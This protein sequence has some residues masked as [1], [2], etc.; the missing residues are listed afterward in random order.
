MPASTLC[1]PLL[2]LALLA[3]PADAGIPANQPTLELVA[4]TPNQSYQLRRGLSGTSHFM[5]DVRMFDAANALDRNGNAV[6]GL[7]RGYHEGYVNLGFREPFFNPATKDVVFWD[8]ANGTPFDCDNGFAISEQVIMPT[9]VYATRGE[10]CIRGILGHE[11][12]HHVE[13]GYVNDGGGT[14]CSGGYGSTACEG[15]ARAMQDKVY[16][17]LDLD[18]AAS[19]VATFRGEANGYLD[20]P[21][22][23]IWQS[24]YRSALFWTY[25]MEQYG[26][27][28][29]EPGLGADFL[30]DWWER[31]RDQMSD[32][33]IIGVTDYQIKQAKPEDH[34]TNAFHDFT[35]A[36]TLKARDLTELP[37]SARLRY[38]YRDE[39]PVAVGVNKM[40]FKEAAISATIPVPAN[41][42][43]AVVNTSAKRFGAR[44]YNFQTESC[45][46]GNTIRFAVSPSVLL[47][48][49]VNAQFIVPD[50]LF[51]LIAIEGATGPGKPRRLYKYR[52]KSWQQTLIQPAAHY[53][54]LTVIV[55]GWHTDFAGSLSVSC[56]APPPLPIVSQVNSQ[57]PM[58]SGAAGSVSL[59]EFSVDLQQAD[60]SGLDTMDLPDF[61]LTIDPNGGS[62][63]LPAVQKVREA[64][65]RI[66]CLALIPSLPEGLYPLR[67]SAAGRSVDI[68]GGLRVGAHQPEVIVAVDT[69]SSM[70]LPAGAAR[71]DA[72]KYAALRIGQS[73]P[74]ASRLGL[75][76]F[77][78][79]SSTPA[80]NVSVLTA[81]A[82]LTA[83]QRQQWQADLGAIASSG[84][85]SIKLGDVLTSSISSFS[86]QGAGGERHL[87]VF[88]DGGDVPAFDITAFESQ[89]RAAGVRVH[90]VALGGLA[91][92]P[93]LARIASSTGGGYQYL[94]VD[95]SGL[96]RGALVGALDQLMDR[97]GR[98]QTVI[99]AS[100][101]TGPSTPAVL[102]ILFDAGI[103]PASGPHVKIFD[104][105][106]AVP[107]SAVRLY[108]PDNSLVSAG[109]DVEIFLSARGFSYQIRNAPSGQW[110]LEVDP[111]AAGGAI[112][113]DYSAAVVDPARGLRLAFARAAGDNELVE[114]F[115]VG[116]PVLVQ[117]ALTDISGLAAP[118]FAQATLTQGGGAPVVL[119]LRDDGT[120]GDQFANDRVYSALYRATDDGSATA[121]LDDQTQAGADGSVRVVASVNLGSAAAQVLLNAHG[122]FAITRETVVADLDNDGLPD[123]FEL[124]QACLDPAQNDAAS[125]RDGDGASNAAEYL[126]G[127]DPCDV[128]TDDGGETDGS[129]IAAGRS[130]LDSLDDALPRIGN[131]EIVTQLNDHEEAADLPAF[132][133]SLRFDSNP[134]YATILVKRAISVDGPW[135]DHAVIDATAADGSYVDPGLMPGQNYC[136]QLIGRNA[137]QAVAAASDI[138]CAQARADSTAPR[139]SVILNQGDP[140]SSATLL[141][142][143]IAVDHESAAG[144]QMR[145]RLPDG[146][147]TGWIPYLPQYPVGV[148]M[149]VPPTVAA[150][151]LQLR[152]PAGNESIEY[153]DDIDLVPAATLGAISGSVRVDTRF[154]D[155]D[156]ALQGVYV[157]PADGGESAQL[158]A[159]AGEFTLPDLPPGSYRLAF[160]RDGYQTQ[161]LNDILVTAG[162]TESIGVVRLLPRPLFRDGFED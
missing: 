6:P 132:S 143:S 48:Q 146:S 49:Q 84:Q 53:N 144:M 25:L 113:F 18:P 131:I 24:S 32:P 16:S 37:E 151:S 139:G 89:A 161:Y 46:T 17:D 13:F 149:L 147:D 145:L 109:P 43:P 81:L 94:P 138:V 142:A 115:R 118:A 52:A 106:S 93:L 67:I 117:A 126:A 158:S 63:L 65:S 33:S 15:H 98:R 101:S 96:D 64:A 99:A 100:A 123:R 39:D 137:T 80:S 61:G 103:E 11:L 134:G 22:I 9:S 4:V 130:P 114:Y 55:S 124:R 150:V 45:P 107:F 59:A 121:I 122:S 34:V 83:A 128:D 112:S 110:R 153:G 58:I 116:E 10:S 97:V 129:E 159:A 76:S 154:G 141:T 44:Y 105:V 27:D 26:H 87:L 29:S 71:L 133:H 120:Q 74:S 75:L 111:S 92:Q 14:G 5:P 86:G 3:G 12:F 160:E 7:P 56:L 155:A 1:R 79:R 28:R 21:N 152:D 19:C 127:S 136:Y 35:I 91:D 95:A 135:T 108:R 140:R 60:G 69:S 78:G 31:A 125:D 102:P 104:G 162:A 85:S 51:S 54:R 8:C 156:A 2:L 77:A 23:N 62:V 41:G 88:T 72:V 119:Q 73:L 82:P 36:N 20:A 148:S 66:R 38:S 68:P 70:G 90:I 47:P 40:K 57:S 30:V 42:T 50:G 157:L